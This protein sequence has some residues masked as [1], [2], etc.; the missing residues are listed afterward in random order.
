MK[1]KIYINW[2]EQFISTYDEVQEEIS[3]RFRAMVEDEDE[4][5]NWLNN[6]SK[7]ELFLMD[8]D[9]KRKVQSKFRGAIMKVAAEEVKSG[10]EE[11]IL[12]TE[13]YPVI[14]E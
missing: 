14:E 8:E 9:E 11:Y 12:N 3:N 2:E 6:Y 1:I 10:Y 13:N 7:G 5:D 4:W